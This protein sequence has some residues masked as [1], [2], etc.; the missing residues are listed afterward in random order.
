MTSPVAANAAAP[1]GVNATCGRHTRQPAQPYRM[2]AARR[3]S[4]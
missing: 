3:G 2:A 1:S 4:P